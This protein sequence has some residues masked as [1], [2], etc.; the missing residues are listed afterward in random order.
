MLGIGSWLIQRGVSFYLWWQAILMLGHL[1]G[2]SFSITI[3]LPLYAC[4]QWIIYICE[5]CW[6]AECSIIVVRK[7]LMMG[8]QKMIG[9]LSCVSGVIIVSMTRIVVWWFVSR[10]MLLREVLSWCS[11]TDVERWIHQQQ[12]NSIATQMQCTENLTKFLINMEKWDGR[13]G[14]IG[15]C[16]VICL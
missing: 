12:L 10:C 1:R 3:G 5:A 6:M 14:G 7:L 13:T 15:D 2:S 4:M 11:W 9:L 8:S 16:M